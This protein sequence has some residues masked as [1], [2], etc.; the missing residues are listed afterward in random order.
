M[1]KLTLFTCPKPFT[2]PHIRQ[3]QRN[4]I[5]SWLQ[6]KPRPEILL[7]GDEE[8]TAEVAVEFGVRHIPKLARNEYGTPLVSSIFE[9]AEIAASHPLLCY[10]NADIILLNDFMDMEAVNSIAWRQDRFLM[11]GQ[12][13]DVD[14][15]EQLDFSFPHWELDLRQIVAER[16]V[17]HAVTGIDYFLFP[18]NFW[19]EIL[20]FALG[21]TAWDN[22]LIYRARARGAAL[23]DATQ[24]IT[25][26]HQNH[27]YAHVPGGETAAWE[28]SE[29]IRNRVLV[30][31]SNR[32][33]LVGDA[34]HRIAAGCLIRNMD[35]SHLELR[36]RRQN[37]LDQKTNFIAKVRRQLLR[38]VY[39]YRYRLP[40]LLW[41]RAVYG[42]SL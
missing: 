42:L 16:G 25:A 3:I 8:G 40:G 12:R 23:I 32:L 10:V 7:L 27:D 1:D 22:W 19:G 26:V 21:R 41:R 2:D 31:G 11:V 33:F 13:W 35:E 4:A 34:T 38:L 9:Q 36:V 6:L 39:R 37:V 15:K 17:L 14:I 30:G 5:G 20:P 29:A 24:A 28:G 18:R